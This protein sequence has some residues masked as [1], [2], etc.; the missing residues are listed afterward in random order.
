MSASKANELGVKPMARILGFADAEQAPIDFPTAP[1]KAVPIALARAG[2]KAS[3]VDL[4]ELNQAF[5]VVSCANT[6]LLNLDPSKV[7]INGGAVALGHPI[8]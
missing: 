2:I 1:A 8:G 3:D 7:D 5:S 6:K 4:W